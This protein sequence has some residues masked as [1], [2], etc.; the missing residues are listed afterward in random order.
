MKPE[1]VKVKRKKLSPT[2]SRES[3]AKKQNQPY[4][5][6][7]ASK[8]KF[9]YLLSLVLKNNLVVVEERN[10]S[11]RPLD[12]LI[13]LILNQSTSDL[14]ADRALADLKKKYKS[15]EDIL[16]E[17][18][19]KKLTKA[20][21]ICGLAPT[22]AQYILN[23]LHYLR[24]QNWLDLDL[25]F[26]KSMTDAEAIKA[27]TA[28]K[29]VGIKSASCLLMFAFQR[30]TFPIDTHLMRIFKRVGGIFLK[31]NISIEAAHKAL[32]PKVAGVEA[33]KLHVSLIELGRQVCKAPQKPFC[34]QCYLSNI[35][36]YAL[37]RLFGTNLR[38]L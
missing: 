36:D 16:R 14:L 26:I 33:F 11:Q 20:I 10:T 24:A 2:K 4:I 25:T 13:L 21:Q 27:L 15:Y 12:L 32:Q 22:K 17:N 1:N 6:S 38:K 8:D 23:T 18:N 34:D 9:A 19:A 30:G 7:N 5:A 29:G 35:C 31:D 28:I 3:S 37:E